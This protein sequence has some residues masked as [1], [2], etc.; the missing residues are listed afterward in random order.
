MNFITELNNIVREISR[1]DLPVDYSSFSKNTETPRERERDNGVVFIQLIDILECKCNST[2]APSNDTPSKRLISQRGRE[3]ERKT[4]FGSRAIVCAT[5]VP[6][7][8]CNSDSTP[9]EKGDVSYA[10]RRARLIR[11]SVYT[12]RNANY[13]PVPT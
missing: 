13:M 5:S 4:I 2:F 1:P 7:V 12:L 6:L 10:S 11:T 8:D 3:I 9:A